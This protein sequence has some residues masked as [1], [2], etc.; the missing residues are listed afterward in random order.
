[1]GWIVLDGLG[2]K[3]DG[4]LVLVG[5]GLGWIIF[6]FGLSRFV[7]VLFCF[8]LFCLVLFGFI[9]FGLGLVGV[10]LVCLGLVWYGLVWFGKVWFGLIYRSV[11]IVMTRTTG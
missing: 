9:L 11:Q 2:W 4:G 1:M 10:G 8:V 7:S 3:P 6:G 5:L